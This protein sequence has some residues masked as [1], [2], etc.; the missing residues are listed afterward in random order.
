MTCSTASSSRTAASPPSGTQEQRRLDPQ[1]GAGAS[2][3]PFTHAGQL[4]V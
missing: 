3:L 1:G 2:Q 4:V